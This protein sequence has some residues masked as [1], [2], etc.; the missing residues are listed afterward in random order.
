[1]L[2]TAIRL[3]PFGVFDNS[4]QAA[5][6]IEVRPIASSMGA[7]VRA[8]DIRSMSD[9]AFEEFRS[10]LF[11]H[12]M[13]FIRGQ[14]LTHDEHADFTTR[15]GAFGADSFGSPTDPHPHVL[16]V[17]KEADTRTPVVFGGVW[18]TDSPFLPHPPAITTLRS[19]EV[20]PFGGDTTWADTALAYRA[21]SPTMRAMIEPL[22]V[23]M[24]SERSLIATSKGR[25]KAVRGYANDQVSEGALSGTYHPLV[26]THPVTGEKALYVDEIYTSGIEGLTDLE[27]RPLIDFLIGHITQHQFCCRLRWE[28]DMLVLW[29]NRLCLH[30]AMNDYDGYRRE[31]YRTTVAPE[32]ASVPT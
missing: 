14:R 17:I 4:A 19:V 10:A 16:P 26:S 2:Q 6:H 15:F 21:L 1:M 30:L 25:G 28:P 22:R 11:R 24:T 13:I 3:S 23:H 5:R 8:P 7:E 32:A 31:M 27:S 9:E 20:P 29:D 12:R 18:H